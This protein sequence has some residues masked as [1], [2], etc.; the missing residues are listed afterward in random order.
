MPTSGD[1]L[2][3][4]RRALVADAYTRFG[5]PRAEAEAHATVLVAALEG[6]LILARAQRT[7]EPLDEVERFFSH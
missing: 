1:D 2:R 7:L 4:R 5:A 6:A 3:R